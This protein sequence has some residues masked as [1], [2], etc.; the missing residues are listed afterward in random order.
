M[1]VEVQPTVAVAIGVGSE[2]NVTVIACF[3]GN[4]DPVKEIEVGSLV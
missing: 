4:P 3:I 2:S 1:F